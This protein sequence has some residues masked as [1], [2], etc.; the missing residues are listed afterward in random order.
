MESRMD[1]P[2]KTIESFN[3]QS[4]LNQSLKEAM[5]WAWSLEMGDTMFAVVNTYIRQRIL[6]YN[7]DD[8]CL[9]IYHNHIA[10]QQFFYNNYRGV[11]NFG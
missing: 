1:D 9:K 11:A 3:R 6:D 4:Q 10:C 8:F 2:L 5:E 7:E